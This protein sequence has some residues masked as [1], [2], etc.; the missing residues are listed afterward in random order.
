MVSEI[1][2]G[3]ASQAHFEAMTNQ[4][5]PKLKRE[6]TILNNRIKAVALL[7]RVGYN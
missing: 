7:G 1:L 2:R 6:D 4:R 5:L 3:K